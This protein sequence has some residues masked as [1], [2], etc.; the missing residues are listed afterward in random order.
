[1]EQRHGARRLDHPVE[2]L[3]RFHPVHPVEGAAHD[4]Q[5]EP[6]QGRAEVVGTARDKADVR[7]LAGQ[8]AGRVQHLRRG[9]HRD[10]LVGERGE[11]AGQRTR[12]AAKV[13]HSMLGPRPT[14]SATR[15]MSAA[16]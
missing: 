7:G 8:R 5:V 4:D 3:E 6:P 14:A 2:P 11:A 12:A 13:E 10:H 1:V 15:R 16:A 9:V